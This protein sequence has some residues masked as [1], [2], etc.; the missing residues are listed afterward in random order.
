MTSKNRSGAKGD[1]CD[2]MNGA[3]YRPEL[4]REQYKRT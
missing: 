1:N 2:S 3:F 4:N